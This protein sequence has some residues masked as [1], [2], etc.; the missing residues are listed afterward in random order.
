M[1]KDALMASVGELFGV[2]P[3]IR[4]IADSLSI[5][6]QTVRVWP[7]DLGRMHLSRIAGDIIRKGK[8]VPSDIVSALRASN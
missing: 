6:T 5:T 4:N 2:E 1:K 3:T 7:D 8:R